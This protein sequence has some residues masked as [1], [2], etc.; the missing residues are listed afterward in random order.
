V[1]TEERTATRRAASSRALLSP[2]P[3]SGVVSVRY[4]GGNATGGEIQNHAERNAETD[5]RGSI[6]CAASPA[7]VTRPCQSFP[8]HVL[9]FALPS[10]S[11]TSLN[12]LLGSQLVPAS[13]RT[14]SASSATFS[15][16]VRQGCTKGAARNFSRATREAGVLRSEAYGG[17]DHVEAS[18]YVHSA[19]LE[20]EPSRTV[21]W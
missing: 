8:F 18:W 21:A 19:G 5:I 4:E 14:P 6:V 11:V 16:A 2:W 1:K 3:R 7:S 10:S 17:P 9:R 15:A 20:D 13:T 12:T